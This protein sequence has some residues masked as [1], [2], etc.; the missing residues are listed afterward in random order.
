[1]SLKKTWFSY[2]LW[3]ILA[4]LTGITAYIAT[5][6]VF[7]MV[8]W[9]S[10]ILVAGVVGLYV[11]VHFVCGKIKR[12]ALSKWP[13]RIIHM[14]LFLLIT[15]V[16]VYLRLPVFTNMESMVTLQQMEWF[17]DA[18]KVGRDVLS[19]ASITTVVEQIYMNLLSGLF[20]FLGN[21]MELLVYAQA[22]FQSISF[23]MLMVIGHTLQ[24]KV[25]AWIPAL[26]YAVSPFM[27]SAIGDVGPANFWTCVVLFGMVIVCILQKTWKNRNIT[28]MVLVAWQML[29]AVIYYIIKLDVFWYGNPTYATGG[30][31]KGGEG[32]LGIEMLLAVI[33]LIG[34]CAS[35]YFDKQDHRILYTIPFIFDCIILTFAA[36]SEYESCTLFMMLAAVNLYFLMTESLRVTFRFKPETVTGQIKVKI[37]KEK[38]I[39]EER[40]EEAFDWEEMK[41]VMKSSP[42]IEVETPEVKEE[43]VLVEISEVKEEPTPVKEE[44]VPVIDRRAPIENVLPMPKK[45]VPK[46]LDYAFEPEDN[47]M[48]YDVEIENDDYDY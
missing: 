6:K 24:R 45:H 10:V 14:L 47:M 48:H 9:M 25:Y 31:L 35:F 30:Y 4:G 34:Y 22:V 41:T 33:V 40:K 37:A 2:V 15:A 38:P 16:F 20:L 11:L 27:Y 32:F 26:L 3:F 29:F 12:I 17:Y 18:T 1:M 28:Y 39:K 8:P 23:V 7:A 43:P 21:K 44:P 36:F 13:V 42:E 46:V 5:V 19:I